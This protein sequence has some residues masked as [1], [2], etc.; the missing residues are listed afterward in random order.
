MSEPSEQRNLA[1]HLRRQAGADGLTTIVGLPGE[2][3]DAGWQ[4]V[5]LSPDLETYVDVAADDV[6][7]TQAVAGEQ[8]GLG[9][10][11]V[12]VRKGARLRYTRTVAADA[13]SAF[14]QG[15]VTERFLP[16]SAPAVGPT[17]GVIARE[18]C[19]YYT[20]DTYFWC[21]SRYVCFTG[22]CGGSGWC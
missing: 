9:A 15:P 3:D 20:G 4:R 22:R 7:H 16:G 17:R 18:Y 5:Y 2:S 6:L 12:W 8:G 1:D 21:E 13:Q 11:M 14:L 10:T 19:Q